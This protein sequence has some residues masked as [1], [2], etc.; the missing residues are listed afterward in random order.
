MECPFCY[1][2]FEYHLSICTSCGKDTD[3]P[4][5]QELFSRV[6]PRKV[7]KAESATVIE[8]MSSPEPV[9]EIPPLPSVSSA[10]PVSARSMAEEKRER[11]V[12]VTTE[13]RNKD[14]CKTL[15][16]FPGKKPE[17]PEWRRELQSRIKEVQEQRV[18]AGAAGA[19]GSAVASV[20]ASGVQ[21]A[22]I[23]A[24]VATKHAIGR[25]GLAMAL[26]ETPPAPVRSNALVEK[27]L[28]RI[29]KSR[30]NNEDQPAQKP[31][32]PYQP[33]QEYKP[34]TLTERPKP[35]V[36][37]RE[38]EVIMREPETMS[39]GRPFIF[40]E[41]ETV[42][43][44]L[45][46]IGQTYQE[47]LAEAAK[48]KNDL[49]AAGEIFTTSKLRKPAYLNFAAERTAEKIAEKTV[50]EDENFRAVSRPVERTKT[51]LAEENIPAETFEDEISEE[52]APF[53]YRFNAGF[54]DFII[55][56]FLSLILLTPFVMFGGSW[57]SYEGAFAFAATCSIVMFLY[58]TAAVGL[59]GRTL[60]MG[61]FS[62][63][64]IDAEDSDY[65]TF[66]QAAI[67]SSL[68]L[69]SLALGGIGFARMF[70]N[71]D[72]RA[73]HDM[74]SGTIVVREV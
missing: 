47:R 16:D 44:R 71:D 64:M 8:Q 25:T 30:I 62:L 36:V 65:P 59:I 57:F 4:I 27:A 18:A 21:P 41:N 11:S 29:E 5:Y 42:E 33:Y 1:T 55:S 14:T 73:V 12:V 13:I 40:S 74:I 26:I 70:L 48:V 56:G 50:K 67:S 2:N 68:Y 60:G 45:S 19:A 7:E 17:V 6:K 10:P 24:I 23:S 28:A 66:H 20:A 34:L 69:V 52:V 38:E 54:F 3:D 53:V 61:L 58:I 9:L 37:I 43:S 72:K 15:M 39:G 63:E 35:V 22:A 46:Q 49:L 51:V 31:Y 32:Q